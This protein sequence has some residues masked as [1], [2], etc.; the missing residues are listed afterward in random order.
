M[1]KLFEQNK[2]KPIRDRIADCAY[3]IAFNQML[4]NRCYSPIVVF[5]FRMFNN[6]IQ[7]DIDKHNKE[8]VIWSSAANANRENLSNYI[9]SKLPTWE[10]IEEYCLIKEREENERGRI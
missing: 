10:E 7:I 5:E 1:I 6:T 8:C 2:K 3:S 4:E 9:V